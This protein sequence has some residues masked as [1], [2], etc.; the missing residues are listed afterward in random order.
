M[1]IIG[2]L[3]KRQKSLSKED[4]YGGDLSIY[5]NLTEFECL[6][7]ASDVSSQKY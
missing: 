6:L 1:I 7:I 3:S 2:E 4:F 5:E